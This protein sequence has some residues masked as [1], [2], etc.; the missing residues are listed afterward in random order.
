SRSL[1]FT[2]A[3]LVV[4]TGPS[5]IWAIPLTLIAYL[6]AGWSA[7]RILYEETWGLGVYLSFMIR[8]FVANWSFWLLVTTLPAIARS[9]GDRAW[10]VAAVMGPL[11][12]LYAARQAEVIRWLIRA[13]PITDEAIRA[14]FD[15]LVA[16]CG[17]A[18][19]R[20][21]VIDLQ[22]GRL[23]NGFALPSL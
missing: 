23:A 18:A 3:L 15:R 19:P 11:L 13:R 5:A 6:A 2:I 10:I 4:V 21:E 14:R 8:F 22:G 9:A 20:F 16:A 1:I 17:I 12:M 7:R